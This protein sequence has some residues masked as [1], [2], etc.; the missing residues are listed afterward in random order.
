MRLQIWRQLTRHWAVRNCEGGGYAGH[1]RTKMESTPMKEVTLQNTFDKLL[2]DVPDQ[3]WVVLE[4]TIRKKGLKKWEI[5]EGEPFG[6]NVSTP[7]LIP[8]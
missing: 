8:E 4:L 3:K 7:N 6:P 2:K 5:A 1:E